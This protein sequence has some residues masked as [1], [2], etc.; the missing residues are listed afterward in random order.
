MPAGTAPDS[1]L[2]TNVMITEIQPNPWM[3]VPFIALLA[4]IAL[5]PL[6]F[7]DWWGKH[8]PKVALALAALV[9]AYYLLG[10]RATPRVL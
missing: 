10:L 6:W 5:A 2:H 1:L 3:V 7:A 8:Y 4:A 9:A